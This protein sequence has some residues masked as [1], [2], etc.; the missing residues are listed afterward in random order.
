MQRQLLGPANGVILFPLLRRPIAARRKQPMQH[1]HKHRPLERE[2]K[3]PR[4]RQL[5]H[6]RA[7]ARLLPQP[8]EDQRR[9][10][11]LG[12]RRQTLAVGVRSEYRILLREAPERGQQPIQF[13]A[14]PQLVESP[15]AMKHPLLDAPVDALILDQEQV[16]A[17]PV[18]LSADEQALSMPLR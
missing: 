11:G 3:P 17:I 16:G 13:A 14:G 1:R 7:D 10:D 18:G 2:L 12:A 4:R 6:H 15:Q 5:P 9:T 8:L